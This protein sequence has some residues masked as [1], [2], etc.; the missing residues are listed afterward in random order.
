MNYSLKFF[1]QDHQK[2]NKYLYICKKAENNLNYAAK[3]AV[4]QEELEA[5][6]ASLDNISDL[7]KQIEKKV[8]IY[9]LL[10]Q[11]FTEDGDILDHVQTW[12]K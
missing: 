10:K 2:Y 12:S 11:E 7:E 5:E 6:K 1:K 8:S 9:Y 3:Y 4:K